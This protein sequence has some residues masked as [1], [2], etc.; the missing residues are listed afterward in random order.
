MRLF[1][2]SLLLVCLAVLLPDFAAAQTTS[3]PAV[4]TITA[5][6]QI[7]RQNYNEQ[8]SEAASMLQVARDEFTAAG[9]FVQS[10]RITTQPFPEYV[11]G[12]STAQAVAFLRTLDGLAVAGHYGLNIGPAMRSDRDDASMLDVLA[13]FLATSQTTNASVHLVRPTSGGPRIQW[14]VIDESVELIQALKNNSPG[15]GANFSFAAAAMVEPYSPFFPASWHDGPGRRFS[16]GLQAAN[17]MTE[18]FSR[19]GYQPDRAEAELRDELTA[20]ARQVEKLGQ[21]VQRGTSWKYLGLD[22]TAATFGDMASIGTAMEAFTGGPL[23]SGGTLTAAEIITSAVRALPVRQVGLRGLMLPVL[24]DARIAARWGEGRL[25]LD[26]LLSYSS[27]CGTGLDTVPLPG[28]VTDA[29]L[30]RILGDVAT[31]SKKWKKALTARL[32]PVKGLRAGDPT[33]FNNPFLVDTILQPL[34]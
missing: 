27:V 25:S 24:E 26:S 31:L 29:Q 23:G 4:R 22:P 1:I 14:R 9:W 30:K 6:V 32:L 12:L 18:V 8:L 7:D 15:S 10:V 3:R 33:A 2:G 28:D 17:V 13:E 21:A 34:P 16:V 19:T 5:F 11:S 20:H